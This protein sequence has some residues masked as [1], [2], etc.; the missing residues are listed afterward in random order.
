MVLL[1]RNA[2]GCQLDAQ[3]D[4]RMEMTQKLKSRNTPKCTVSTIGK[5]KQK[6]SRGAGVSCP[7]LEKRWLRGDV[8]NGPLTGREYSFGVATCKLSS[9]NLQ[10][11]AKLFCRGA[12]TLRRARLEQAVSLPCCTAN[13][14]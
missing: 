11:T 1:I 12:V 6:Q 8:G 7:V 4:G 2:E 10:G 9:P 14:L 13:G 5:G 3:T